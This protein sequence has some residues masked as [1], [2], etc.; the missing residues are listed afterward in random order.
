MTL[1][2]YL[3]RYYGLGLI[4]ALIA[5]LWLHAVSTYGSDLSP[6]KDAVIWSAILLGCWWLPR[7][8]S[9]FQVKGTWRNPST[10]ETVLY[11]RLLLAALLIDFGSKALFF[12]WDRPY[13]VEVFKNFGLHSVFHPADFE[14]FHLIL[15]LYFSYVFVLGALFFRFTNKSVDR[16][17]LI[18]SAFALAGAVALFSE[19]FMFGGVHDS[20][21]FAGKLMWLCPP[22]ASP[23][24]ASYAWTPADFFVHAAF[25]PPLILLASYFLPAPSP[26]NSL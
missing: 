2:N 21:Y 20:F 11:M 19:R 9:G 5:P 26:A 12:R 10:V 17:W 18:S 13:P 4:L 24:F 25:A 1:L 3:K 14:P 22:C 16:V 6:L 23:Y 8:Y 15:L 7:K